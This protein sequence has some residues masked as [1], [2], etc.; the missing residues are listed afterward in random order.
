MPTRTS[1]AHGHGTLHDGN[2]TVE[3]GSGAFEGPDSFAS[4]FEDAAGTNP[5]ELIGAAHA[6]CFAQSLALLL[7]KDGFDPASIDTDA[8]VT[9]EQVDGKPAITSSKLTVPA[10]VPGL[11]SASFERHA[12]A[13]KT[14]CPVAKALTGTEI[15]L[16]ADRVG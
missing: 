5:E 1:H 16:E 10:K 7:E 11:D 3:L 6:G 15:T 8:D 2:G 12:Q 14:D 9:V 4:R 13:A